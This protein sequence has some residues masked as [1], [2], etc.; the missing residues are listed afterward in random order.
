MAY[1]SHAL[2][3]LFYGCPVYLVGSGIVDPDPNDLDIVI[4]IPD[5]LFEARY[6]RHV[7][8]GFP[9]S[10]WKRWARDCAKIGRELTMECKRSVD[11]KT[12]PRTLFES[13]EKPR[14]RLDCNLLK[15]TYT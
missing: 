6:G 13:I 11:F 2:S 15:D 1:C 8:D 5:E 3:A 14:L 10:Q 7:D 4:P 9:T 12:Q